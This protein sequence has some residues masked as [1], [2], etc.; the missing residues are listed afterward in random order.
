MGRSGGVDGVVCDEGEPIEVN[1][2]AAWGKLKLLAGRA[3]ARVWDGDWQSRKSS[4]LVGQEF[5]IRY[6]SFNMGHSRL[7]SKAANGAWC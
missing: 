5:W 1:G 2:V 7:K 3:E 4:R 6:L